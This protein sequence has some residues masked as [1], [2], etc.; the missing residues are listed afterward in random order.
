MIL[1]LVTPQSTI[2]RSKRYAD[3]NHAAGVTNLRQ[4]KVGVRVGR[5]L[6]ASGEVGYRVALCIRQN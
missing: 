2:K 5:T 6:G 1:V 4:T 3:S